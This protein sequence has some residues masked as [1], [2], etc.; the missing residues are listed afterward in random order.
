MPAAAFAVSGVRGQVVLKIFG[1]DLD[2]MKATLERCVTALKPVPGIVDLS[3]YRDASVPQLQVILDRSAL[4]RAGITVGAAEDGPAQLSQSRID[5]PAP[6]RC[7]GCH[8]AATWS[9]APTTSRST[10]FSHDDTARARPFMA[11]A[12]MATSWRTGRQHLKQ[13]SEHDR[14]QSV[15]HRTGRPIPHRRARNLSAD[16]A[17][18][19]PAHRTRPAQPKPALR[20][21][22][23]RLRRRPSAGQPAAA[24]R[25]RWPAGHGQAAGRRLVQAVVASSSTSASESRDRKSVV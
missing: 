19:A 22:L 13:D 16:A 8:A 1:T 24:V 17:R 2:L 15:N 5:P 3:L 20:N 25:W 23:C 6:G 11:A 14:L 4:A 12:G 7:D 21:T 9:S 10:R 18:A